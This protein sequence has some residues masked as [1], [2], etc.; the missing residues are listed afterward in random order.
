VGVMV[1]VALGSGVCVGV[2]VSVGSGVAVALGSVVAEGMAVGGTVGSKVGAAHPVIKAVDTKHNTRNNFFIWL[3]Y[4][5][6]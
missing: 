2:G 3:P 1:G 5:K 6:F 4:V